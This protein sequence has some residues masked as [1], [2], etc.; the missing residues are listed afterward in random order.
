M[1]VSG[2]ESG[3]LTLH[4]LVESQREGTFENYRVRFV[5]L[6]PV[7]RD[8]TPVPAGEYV[9]TLTVSRDR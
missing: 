9:A 2:K 8:T 3:T 4:T 1:Q 6:L 7:P 5:R